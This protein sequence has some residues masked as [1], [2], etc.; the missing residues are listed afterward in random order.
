MKKL[1]TL[2]VIIFTIS[3]ALA[4]NFNQNF[5]NKSLRIDY[6]R[7]G[8][9]E[10]EK[11][12]LV[13][14]RYFDKWVGSQTNLID[15]FYYGLNY[16]F[17][18]DSLS[19]KLIYSR[20]YS[21][22][23]E[24]WKTTK[25]AKETTKEFEESVIVPFPKKSIKIEF[26][27]RNKKGEFELLY[28]HY[29]DPKKV[30]IQ[31]NKR[32]EVQKIHQGGEAPKCYDIVIIP[33]GYT[34]SDSLKLKSDFQKFAD[35]IL[36]C[37]P[38]SNLKHKI[39][40]NGIFCFSEESGITDPNQK[41]FKNT[42]LKTSFNT[43]ESDRYLMTTHFWQLQNIA[44]SSP[45]DGILII[46]N[47]NKYGGGGIFNYY[48][49]TSSDNINSNFICVHEMGHSLA[50]LAD[51][52]YTSEVSVEDFYPTQIEPWEPNITTFIDFDRKWKKDLPQNTKIP[53]LV[54]EKNDIIGVYEGAGYQA[55]GIY[56]PALHCTMKEVRYNNFC[57]VCQNAIEK[58]INFYSK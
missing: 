41:E 29:L 1:I 8:N 20:G 18:Y 10:N 9:F 47:T 23:F 33:D 28:Q 24:E 39:N 45:Y 43:I 37:K 56:R 49:T 12:K 57:P 48:A 50:G 34:K 38:Y 54:D 11:I 26:K 36:K 22:L 5:T 40:I 27:S 15:T 6:Y 42:I 55:K 32:Y 31:N 35:I 51:E 21:C 16:V 30:K 13:D 53:T 52:Y 4:Q 3:F 46:C 17:V 44:E 25:E 58:M 7:Y 2:F 14:N 19:N